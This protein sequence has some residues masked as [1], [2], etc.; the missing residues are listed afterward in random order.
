MGLLPVAK[1]QLTVSVPRKRVAYL[2]QITEIERSFPISVHDCVLLGCWNDVGAWGQVSKLMLE[3]V[4]LALSAVGLQGFGRR[5]VGSLS[6][7]QLQRVLFARLLVQDA[8]LIL[9]DEPFN[10]VDSTT[11]T[12][13]MAL[14]HQWHAQKR[15]VI[16]VVHDD[17][18]VRQHFPSTVLLA[19]EL[20]AWGDTKR[21]LTE[22]NLS[23]AR[24]MTEAWD[25]TA[26]LCHIDTAIAQ[27]LATS[28]NV[29]KDVA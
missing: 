13:L 2:P 16:T 24:T 23:T 5:I 10:A 6:G 21:V 7:G 19:R 1:S 9:L 18:L 3:R 8:E 26:G 20:V 29:L 4:D 25:D 27:S 22:E 15:T 28:F 14:I 11:L 17:A 12:G